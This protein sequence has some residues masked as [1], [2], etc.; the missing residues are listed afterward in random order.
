M[1]FDLTAPSASA[2]LS[3]PLFVADLLPP[4]TADVDL[5][6]PASVD[7]TPVLVWN[8]DLTPPAEPTDLL[9][10]TSSKPGP[11]LSAGNNV[12]RGCSASPGLPTGNLILLCLAALATRLRR[13]R[14]P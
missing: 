4:T 13:R 12:H 14:T 10:S 1:L 9:A 7:L 2:D 5:T 8:D 3:A 6:P 11:D